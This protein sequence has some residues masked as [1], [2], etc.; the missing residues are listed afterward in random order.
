MSKKKWIAGISAAVIIAV[1]AVLYIQSRPKSMDMPEGAALAGTIQFQTT[2]EDLTSTVEVKGTSSYKKE[3]YVSA[4]FSA[5]VAAWSVTEGQQVKK[6]DI[7]FHL[8][9]TALKS[10]ISQLQASIKRIET[11]QK[12]AGISSSTEQTAQSTSEKEAK[13]RFIRL[14][15]AKLETEAADLELDHSRLLLAE[16]NELLAQAVYRAPEDGIF[17]FEDKKQPQALNANER[18]GRIVDLDELQLIAK[19]GEYDLFRLKE[20]MAVTVKVDAL[21]D[22]KLSGK[23]VSLSK[24]AK[25]AAGSGAAQFEVVISLEPY[26]QLIAGLSLTASIETD[27]KTG[28]LVIPTLAVQRDG[29]QY[30]VMAANNGAP[31]RRNIK[32]GLETSEKT[33][34]VEGLSEGEVVLLQ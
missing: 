9:D 29:D 8:D 15:T 30:Y 33:E 34:V 12:I 17:L 22:V 3:T 32:I 6:G 21:K 4:P 18:A 14:E 24:F 2:R 1:S 31:E 10:E 27:R 13:E 25:D 23:V 11:N 28:V 19:V 5:K 26:E 16:K 7:L 20:D